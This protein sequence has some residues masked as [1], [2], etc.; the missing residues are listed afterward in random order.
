VED[1]WLKTLN[2]FCRTV[3]GNHKERTRSDQQMY[4]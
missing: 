3:L 2:S 1:F 4:P